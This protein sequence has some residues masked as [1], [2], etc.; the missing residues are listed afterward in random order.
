[1]WEW[2]LPCWWGMARPGSG[3]GYLLQSKCPGS[4]ILLS[5]CTFFVDGVVPLFTLILI[6]IPN[7]IPPPAARAGFCLERLPVLPPIPIPILALSPLPVP[8]PS[9]GP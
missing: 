9:A 1:M 3:A 7:P 5:L 8:A 4:Q 2:L 6:L